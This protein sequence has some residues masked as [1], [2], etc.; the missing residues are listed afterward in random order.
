MILIFIVWIHQVACHSF[1]VS[2]YIFSL[3]CVCR[4]L[5]F[6]S[7]SLLFYNKCYF[8]EFATSHNE[9]WATLRPIVLVHNEWTDTLIMLRFL[10]FSPLQKVKRSI[11]SYYIDGYCIDNVHVAAK[12][13][14]SLPIRCC[15]LLTFQLA[16]NLN[17]FCLATMNANRKLWKQKVLV[18]TGATHSLSLSR[19]LLLSLLPI[20]TMVSFLLASALH[21][22]LNWVYV[23]YERNW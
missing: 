20:K 4:A 2:I 13:A 18:A 7:S 8:E 9:K 14:N 22:T 11:M 10:S 3:Y 1:W 23:Q 16:A 21:L 5:F 6:C 12:R 15:C 17:A 19:S